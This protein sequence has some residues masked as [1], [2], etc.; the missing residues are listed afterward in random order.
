MSTL[1]GIQDDLREGRETDALYD[2]LSKLRKLRSTRG[3]SDE[4]VPDERAIHIILA[5]THIM[6]AEEA[7]GEDT[8]EYGWGAK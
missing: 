8:A 1:S 5:C 3:L 4:P 6:A 7:D 2:V